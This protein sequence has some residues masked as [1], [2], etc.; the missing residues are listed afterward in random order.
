MTVFSLVFT[1][2]LQT[3]QFAQTLSYTFTGPDAHAQCGKA[4]LSSIEQLK[5]DPE[6]SEFDVQCLPRE[7]T[8]LDKLP[9]G[10]PDIAPA[11]KHVPGKDEA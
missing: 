10:H 1:V 4:A 7:F 6:V 2:L 5:N 3:G 8:N 11:P 9:E